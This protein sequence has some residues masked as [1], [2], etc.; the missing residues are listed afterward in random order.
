MRNNVL[1][2]R[3]N[4][5]PR[6]QVRFI[7][8]VCV[9]FGLISNAAQAST[10]ICMGEAISGRAI[11]HGGKGDSAIGSSG[12]NCF[13]SANSL[14]G[15]QIKEVCPIRDI[16]FSV[17]EGPI[18]R[19]EAIVSNRT[20]KRLISVRRAIAADQDNFIF[21]GESV[22]NARDQHESVR[23]LERLP[24]AQLKRRF[25]RYKV[26]ATAGEDCEICA[27]VSGRG[28]AIE[29][30]YDSTGIIVLGIISQDKT[31]KDALGNSIGSSLLD[32]IG[33]QTAQCDAGMWT[34][35]ESPRLDGLSYI[36]EDDERCR[37]S[38][39]GGAGET[40]LPRCARIEAFAIRKR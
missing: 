7:F 16:G 12:D 36:V 38:I 40:I 3:A 30:D 10:T 17:E 31:S 23:I 39:P 8:L 18:C 25:A 1:A 27:T 37:L 22:V 24:I 2:H 6:S 26:V 33:S 20:I 14:I 34:T 15:R 9:M 32:A 21:N 29:V 11:S 13:F 5:D 28:T 4:R 35:C 19:V